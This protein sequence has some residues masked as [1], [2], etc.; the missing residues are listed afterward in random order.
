MNI[1]ID[2]DGEWPNLCS[3]NLVVT[4]DEKVWAFGKY[5]LS[6][7]GSVSFDDDWNENITSGKWSIVNWPEDFPV[8]LQ[9]D[10]LKAINEEIPQGCCGGCV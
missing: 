7:G 9:D 8:E 1:K 4:I 3:G 5:C 2:Y 6:S 10:V